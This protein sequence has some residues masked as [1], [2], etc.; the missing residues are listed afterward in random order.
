MTKEILQKFLNNQY[1]GEELKEVIQWVKKDSLSN[2]SINWGIQDWKEFQVQENGTDS[3]KLSVLLDKIH[4][5]IYISSNKQI[6]KKPIVHITTWLTRAAAILLLPV[7]A[8]LFYT[9]SEKSFD[10]AKYANMAVDSVE[11]IAPIGSRTVVQLSDGSEVYLNYGSK[12]KYPQ[13]FIGNTREV[14][15]SGEGYFDVA[16]NPEKPFIVK[17]GK[18]NIKAL[19]TA[20]NVLAYPDKDVIA[21]T[22]VNGKVVLERTEINGEAETIGAMVPGQ[23]VNYNIKNGAFSCKEEDITKYIAWKDGK[24][25]FENESIKQVGER[26]SRMFNVDIEISDNVMDYTYT[27]TFV[28]EPL[29]QILDLMTLATPVTYKALPRKKLSDGTFSKQKIIIEKRN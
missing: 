6:V 5:K 3:E 1:S 22:L 15:L 11:V 2:S 27:V 25:V 8:F 18:L 29:F 14:I 17:T 28:D 20:F 21:T 9:L 7:L 13:N 4:H 23:H 16:H 26:L 12:I 19:G 10:S 24:L